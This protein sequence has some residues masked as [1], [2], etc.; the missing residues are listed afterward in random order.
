MSLPTDLPIPSSR[1]APGAWATLLLLATGFT[2]SQAFRTVAA[3]MAA[4]LQAEMHLTAQQLGMFAAAFHFAFG[5]LQL[6]MGIGIDMHG[7]RRT[8]L[9]VSPLMV[10]GAV[11]SALATNFPVLVAGQVLIGVG[12]APAFLV[13]TVFIA[14]HFAAERFSAVSSATLAVG[15]TGMLVT[16][17]PLAWLIEVSSWRMGFWVLA[18]CAVASWVAIARWVHEPAPPAGA[19]RESLGEA[20]RTFGQLFR[21][22]YT[23]GIV[24]LGLV[25][26]ASFVALRGLWLGPLMMQRH[27]WSLVAAGNLAVVLSVVALI[28]L[29]LFGRA[30]PGPRRRRRWLVGFT[31]V[32]AALFAA[33]ALGIGASADVAL[34]LVLGLVS[35]FG[36]LQYPDVKNAYE[37]AVIG[38]AMALF[39]MALFMGVALMQWATGAIASAAQAHGVEPFGPVFASIAAMLAAGALAFRWLPRPPSV[40]GRP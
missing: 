4:P 37:P 1:R 9:V 23:A 39:T 6:F 17:T 26:Y 10:L 21:L 30:D 33:M 32:S 22:P 31:L 34:M 35:G 24:A 11:V 2:L 27:G 7:L 18:L 5:G 19:Q 13:C 8:V 20:V 14:R 36:A 40:T 29:P 3:I 25:T 16:G 38:R 12:C 28:S 15:S